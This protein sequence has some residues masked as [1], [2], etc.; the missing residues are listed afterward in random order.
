MKYAGYE[1]ESFEAG[2]DLW[3]A[4]IRRQDNEPVALDGVLFSSLEIGFAWS[5]SDAAIAD[6]K[7]RIDNLIRRSAPVKTSRVEQR[8]A[9]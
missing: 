3:H 5:D 7:S 4:R 6:A 1:I 9:S 8:R 2:K